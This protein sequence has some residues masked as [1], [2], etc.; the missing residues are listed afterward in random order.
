M[1]EKYVFSDSPHKNLMSKALKACGQTL[2][3]HA[4][5]IENEYD[6]LTDIDVYISLSYEDRESLYIP[7]I[8]ITTKHIP[9]SIIK[10]KH[11]EK[12]ND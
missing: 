4:E 9:E 5:S 10:V 6:Y 2:I 7:T 8:E 1:S 11:G 12:S 3:D